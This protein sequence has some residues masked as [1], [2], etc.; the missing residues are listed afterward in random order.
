MGVEYYEK[1]GWGNFMK[2]FT[3]VLTLV[4]GVVGLACWYSVSLLLGVVMALPWLFIISIIYA[5]FGSLK[6]TITPK[7]LVVAY[8]PLN[9]KRFSLHEIETCEQVKVRKYW[10]LGVRYWADGSMMAYL[11]SFGSA[12]KIN[13]IGKSS[14][15]FSTNH[16]DKIC[17]I[18]STKNNR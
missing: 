10:G 7:E 14:F 1:V 2:A 5:I 3:I 9:H 13:R 18:I 17:S 15:V 16:P 11:T 4:S 6:I 12:V 8:G